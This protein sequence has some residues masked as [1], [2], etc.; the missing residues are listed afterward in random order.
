MSRRLQAPA[1]LRSF[2]AVWTGKNWVDRGRELAPFFSKAQWLKSVRSP[3]TAHFYNSGANDEM[4]SGLFVLVPA[5]EGVKGV[6]K[7]R[8]CSELRKPSA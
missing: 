8:C 5:R 7:S 1:P 3:E 4:K 2:V 6:A